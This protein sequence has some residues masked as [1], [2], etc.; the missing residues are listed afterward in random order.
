MQEEQARMQAEDAQMIQQQQKQQQ[1]QKPQQQ[2]QQQP[3]QQ[4]LI[5]GLTEEQLDRHAMRQEQ[6]GLA[7]EEV[8]NEIQASSGA[9]VRRDGK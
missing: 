2:Q 7:S 5:N 9:R 4:Q 8:I 3:Q 6:L 1:Q